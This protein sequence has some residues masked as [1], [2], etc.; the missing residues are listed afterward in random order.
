[1]EIPTTQ[2][3][4]PGIRVQGGRVEE[5]LEQER[6]AEPP[7][8][9]QREVAVEMQLGIIGD[10]AVD[11]A[12]GQHAAAAVVQDGLAP[13]HDRHELGDAPAGGLFVGT[14]AGDDVGGRARPQDPAEDLDAPDAGTGGDADDIRSDLLDDPSRSG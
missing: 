13:F 3:F 9:A 7:A 2:L 1:M 11:E 12:R 6:R 10:L 5:G 14:D 8:A 4:T